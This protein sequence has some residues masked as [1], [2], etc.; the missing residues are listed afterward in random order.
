MSEK[1]DPQSTG[2]PLT[3]YLLLLIL[4]VLIPAL[5]LTAILVTRTSRLE[6]E[7][8]DNE[9]VQ[10]SRS[11]A[12]ALDREIEASFE[13]L[14]GLATSPALSSG[15]FPTFYGQL[16]NS[17]HLRNRNALLVQPDGQQ[18]VNTRVT[19]G[20]PLPKENTSDEWFSAVLSRNRPTVSDLVM[21][22]V[23]KKW[24]VA[25]SVPVISGDILRYILAMSI[26]PEQIQHIIA[27]EIIDPGWIIVI[28]DSR[29]RIVARS[30]D[31]LDYVG[32][33]ETFDLGCGVREGVDRQRDAANGEYI[34]RGHRCLDKASWRV[35]A[36]SPAA[37]IDAPMRRVWAIFVAAS[38]AFVS[39]SVPL[40][41]LVGRQIS[42]PIT[43]NA[44]AAEQLGLG[45]IVQAHTSPVREANV[46]S[47]ALAN[48]SMALAERSKSLEESE[49][50]FRAVFEQAAVG[51][52]Q[53]GFDG[54]IISLNERMCK[55]LG[56]SRDACVGK[57]FDSFSDNKDA[58][59]ETADFARLQ[60]GEIESFTTER[61]LLACTGDPLWVRITSSIVRNSEARPLYKSSVIED[62]T[63]VRKERLE[64]AQLVAI[65]ESSPD[66]MLSLDERGLIKTWNSGAQ[67]LFGYPPGEIIGQS[68]S[69]LIPQD[70]RESF[71][72]GLTSIAKGS[73]SKSENAMVHKDGSQI[74]VALT[75]APIRSGAQTTGISATIQ[76]VG[77]RKRRDA[78]VLLLNRELAHRVKNSLA[79]VQ[80]LANQT[81]RTSATAKDFRESFQGRLQAVAAATDLLTQTNWG[82]LTFDDVA[83]RQLTPLLAK[84]GEQLRKS[85]PIVKLQPESAVSIGLA[86]Y[87]LGTNAFKYGSWSANG[88]YVQ[89][90]WTRTFDLKDPRL[91]ISWSEHD[92][93]SIAAPSKN[94]FG[95]TLILK[96][97][98][99]ARV[100]RNFD[101][102]GLTCTLD[103]PLNTI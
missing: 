95:S 23:A 102:Q 20:L 8:A 96:G 3:R 94:G 79:I 38:A 53:V 41:Y 28:T 76:D 2:R 73:T 26:D 91:K 22:T 4:S 93:P 30:A 34:V 54:T 69:E 84:P 72:R 14:T 88:G 68:I 78:Q 18:V 16:K 66:A 98:P 5:L 31:Q 56:Y 63:R 101:V 44:V 55:L 45:K 51:F 29:G 65:V 46:V 74:D 37:V 59:A 48:A 52:V 43:A 99:G 39:G 11:V 75:L 100:E 7:R 86:L 81:M 40:A 57:H 27:A 83:T 89:L 70:K 12:S 25:L 9:A 90:T 47:A 92:G 67:T 82:I 35:S 36:F 62:V 1:S 13:S 42:R 85:G 103:I 60:S 61:R 6:K 49:A 97:I 21:G 24:V 58:D 15:D 19:W 17:L 71:E 10:L 33:F 80:S 77:D 32:K 87:E 64:A 50:R